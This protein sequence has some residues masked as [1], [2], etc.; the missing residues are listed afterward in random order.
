MTNKLKF[1]YRQFL[2]S[3]P[4]PIDMIRVIKSFIGEFPKPKPIH[5]S[6]YE[7][8]KILFRQRHRNRSFSI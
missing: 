4:L 7:D 8:Y 5:E 3:L 2:F 6:R 1:S